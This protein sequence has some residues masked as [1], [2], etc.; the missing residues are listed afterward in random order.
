MLRR[1][2]IFGWFLQPGQLYDLY[3]GDDGPDQQQQQGEQQGEHQQGR[4]GRAREN[5][6]QLQQQHHH[7][8]LDPRPQSGLRPKRRKQK[9]KGA[10]M[11][12]AEGGEGGQPE[13]HCKLAQRML[14]SVAKR[15][16]RAAQQADEPL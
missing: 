8:K 14:A 10:G 11:A 13:H 15:Q 5:R 7:G 4:G 3:T 9:C 1:Y 2:S 6:G 12:A 16:R